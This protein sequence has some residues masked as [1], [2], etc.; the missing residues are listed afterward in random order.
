MEVVP[1]ASAGHSHLI[2]GKSR[3]CSVREPF[4]D[5]IA[6]LERQ[7]TLYVSSGPGEAL[8]YKLSPKGLLAVR[9]DLQCE[10]STRIAK[11]FSVLIETIH[12]ASSIS[13]VI[14]QNGHPHLVTASSSLCCLSEPF[15]HALVQ[16]EHRKLVQVNS[17]YE[18]R[19]SSKGVLSVQGLIQTVGG[20]SKPR[21]S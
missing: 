19:L 9:A 8:L 2:I 5:A 17:K 3:Y 13:L 21:A 20:E 11:A 4:L 18:F 12:R 14:E 7:N 10:D 1:D 6:M 15:L 16:L